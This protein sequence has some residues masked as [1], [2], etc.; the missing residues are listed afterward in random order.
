M[1]LLLGLLSLL[2]LLTFLSLLSWLLRTFTA[3]DPATGSVFIFFRLAF[4]LT[5]TDFTHHFRSKFQFWMIKEW[6]EWPQR[7]EHY[8]PD[9]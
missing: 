3:R 2:S 8:C 7:I 5:H 1:S 6:C 4:G 9:E